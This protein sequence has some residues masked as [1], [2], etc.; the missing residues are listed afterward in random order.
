MNSDD[1]GPK[2]STSIV[3]GKILDIKY[4]TQKLELDM[5]P[6]E[7]FTTENRNQKCEVIPNLDEDQELPIPVLYNSTI[8]R[9][10]CQARLLVNSSVII[11][12]NHC[13]LRI[14]FYKALGEASTNGLVCFNGEPVT[15]NNI[16]S[17]SFLVSLW[18]GK[19]G[20]GTSMSDE[21][22]HKLN[23]KYL[24]D[25]L[26]LI[27]G[28][29]EK[30]KKQGK[31]WPRG[32]DKEGPRRHMGLELLSRDKWRR[33]DGWP[34]GPSQ[35]GPRCRTG[36]EH[37]S[38]EKV[39]S[40]QAPDDPNHAKHPNDTRVGKVPITTRVLLESGG[41]VSSLNGTEVDKS[42]SILHQIR[43]GRS[44]GQVR[45]VMELICA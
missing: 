39:V 38:H 36:L 27:I 45:H 15:L 4:G 37:P 3:D 17:L 34:R 12:T 18:L 30:Q 11:L 28:K 10:L 44:K 23:F 40:E 21:I 25:T 35:G 7:C 43:K 22:V 32:P 13:Q 33:G 42:F 29:F 2:L 5:G 24:I 9:N 31:D 20:N 41:G 14:D 19:I 8:L 6:H 1:G 26:A 16:R